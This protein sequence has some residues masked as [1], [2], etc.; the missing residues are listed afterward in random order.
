M[1]KD[2][3]P[4]SPIAIK[5]QQDLQLK[6][7]AERTQQA[8]VRALRK[9]TEFLQRQPDTATEEE[10]RK[11]LLFIKN[12]RN[13]DSSSINVAQCGLKRFFKLTCPRD[14]PTLR[15]LRVKRELKLPTVITI[16]EVRLL[17]RVI[18][19]PSM[20]CFFI[21]VY[22]ES[23][24]TRCG[25]AMRL[26]FSKLASEP[27]RFLHPSARRIDDFPRQVSSGDEALRP[28]S[29]DSRRSLVQSLDCELASGR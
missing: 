3:Y 21:T 17:L 18:Q 26:I 6:G 28:A 2:K 23:V 11:Y 22:A 27:K 14:W 8:Y 19:K 20:L 12:Q 16:D 13:F 24:P 10:L 15:L 7:L 5:F 1:S 29:P 9:F 4:L 25:I